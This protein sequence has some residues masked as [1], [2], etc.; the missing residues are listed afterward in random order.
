M[1]IQTLKRLL[2]S[3][4]IICGVLLFGMSLSSAGAS[5]PRFT[6]T[7]SVFFPVDSFY[8]STPGLNALEQLAH[9]IVGHH[10]TQVVIMGFASVSGE[11]SH[12]LVLSQERAN[13]V[14]LILQ[15]DVR[16]LG[17][18]KINVVSVGRGAVAFLPPSP[19]SFNNRRVD[20]IATS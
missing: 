3:S 2:G 11:A 13:V 18:D 8:V 5:T 12:N 20:L 17:S 9:S 15:R 7:T 14:A 4:L 1:K 6:D 16:S 10:E 19:N